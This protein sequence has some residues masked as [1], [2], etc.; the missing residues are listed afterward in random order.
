MGIFEATDR[1][2]TRIMTRM[3]GPAETEEKT[4]S[5]EPAFFKVKQP[6]KVEAMQY[7]GTLHIAARIGAW[8]F[9]HDNP[10]EYTCGQEECTGMEADHVFIIDTIDGE[11]VVA[12]GD[13]VIRTALGEF[14]C[15]TAEKFN[16][17][18]ERA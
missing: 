2:L 8:S 10:A 12:A 3:Y 11:R 5:C 18:Y 4:T 1:V 6:P 16:E 9:S 14:I 17:T 15:C 13:W 7:D